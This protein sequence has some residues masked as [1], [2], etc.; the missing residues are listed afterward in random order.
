M[1]TARKKKASRT[2]VRGAS[3]GN[4]ARNKREKTTATQ[5]YQTGS[6]A[7]N[8]TISKARST[9]RSLDM[10]MAKIKRKSTKK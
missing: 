5:I 3:G 1:A 9:T 4:Q 2:S 6:N 10:R 7:V 8:K